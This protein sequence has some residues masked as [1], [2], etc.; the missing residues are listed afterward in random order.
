[1]DPLRTYDYLVLT[2]RRVFDWIRP[3]GPQEYSRKLPTWG[4]T[5]DRLLTHVMVSEWYYVQ[6]LQGL[7]VPPYEQWPLR[8]ESP[9]PFAQ[10]EAEWTTQAE[11]TRAALRPVRD[12]STEREYRVTDDDRRAK[13]VT[14]SAGDIATQLVLHEVHHRAQA[15]NMLQQL[16]VAL[17]DMDFNMWMYRRRDAVPER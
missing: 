15:M 3:L 12:W 11:R 1:M 9:L 17:E 2:R 4:R 7:D 8:E 6:R 14:A 13:I 16:G 5:L 10:L